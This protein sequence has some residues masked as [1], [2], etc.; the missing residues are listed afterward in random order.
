MFIKNHIMY[1]KP[2]HFMKNI[3]DDMIIINNF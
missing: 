3:S 2:K 1:G